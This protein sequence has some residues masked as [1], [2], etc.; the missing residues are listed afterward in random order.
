MNTFQQD[1]VTCSNLRNPHKHSY[2]T[3]TISRATF[4]VRRVP[5]VSLLVMTSSSLCGEP[6]LSP[7]P[8]WC[9]EMA[10]TGRSVSLTV[11]VAISAHACV[12][13]CVC[14]YAMVCVCG[15]SSSTLTSV[16]LSSYSCTW[17]VLV[18]SWLQEGCCEHLY[19]VSHG[20]LSDRFGHPCRC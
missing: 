15:L 19:S 10:G 12:H 2:V 6:C 1:Q 3:N 13:V 5:L 9:S 14:V 18:R 7:A 4:Q 20:H 16:Y 17:Y 11:P 8:T